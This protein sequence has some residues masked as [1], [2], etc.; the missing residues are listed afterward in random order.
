MYKCDIDATE[1]LLGNNYNQA[2]EVETVGGETGW[3]LERRLDNSQED[4][5]LAD[6][7]ESHQDFSRK[8]LEIRPSPMK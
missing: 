5:L 8:P 4:V 3:R 2:V 7:I 1:I 6:S